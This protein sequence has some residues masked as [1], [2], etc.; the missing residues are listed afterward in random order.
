MVYGFVICDTD[1]TIAAESGCY[2]NSLEAHVLTIS[3]HFMALWTSIHLDFSRSR[4]KLRRKQ[5]RTMT[6]QRIQTMNSS[7]RIIINTNDS[8]LKRN[9]LAVTFLGVV[10]P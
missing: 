6:R 7:K 10:G 9:K 1:I 4:N 2:V 3:L 8:K 5:E